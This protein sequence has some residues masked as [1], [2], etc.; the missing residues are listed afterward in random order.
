MNCHEDFSFGWAELTPLKSFSG[1]DATT[2][3]KSTTPKKEKDNSGEY[4]IARYS[5]A[6]CPR[7]LYH[8]I[9]KAISLASTRTFR[10]RDLGK[11]EKSF[12]STPT[13]YCIFKPKAY[14]LPSK[15]EAASRMSL[16]VFKICF[17]LSFKNHSENFRIISLTETDELKLLD[18][19]TSLHE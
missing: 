2:G 7:V 14:I 15:N 3:E 10:I 12:E 17:T 6:T 4:I 8:L 13:A 18:S 9:G 5:F 19:R 16:N 11:E 1:S